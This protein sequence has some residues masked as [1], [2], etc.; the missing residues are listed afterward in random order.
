MQEMEPASPPRKF[1][2][3]NTRMQT[4]SAPAGTAATEAAAVA[5]AV[6][7]HDASQEE[8]A[9]ANKV[10]DGSTTSN[11]PPQPLPASHFGVGG[12]PPAGT[13]CSSSSSNQVP[14]TSCIA[15]VTTVPSSVPA[16]NN[17]ATEP[18]TTPPLLLGRVRSEPPPPPPSTPST[19]SNGAPRSLAHGDCPIAPDAA[20]AAVTAADG[21][22]AAAAAPPFPSPPSLS[23]SPADNVESPP[24]SAPWLVERALSIKAAIEEAV[25]SGGGGGSAASGGGGEAGGGGVL[26]PAAQEANARGIEQ[27]AGGRGGSAEVFPHGVISKVCARWQVEDGYEL[28]QQVFREVATTVVSGTTDG[29]ESM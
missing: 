2:S 18:A 7:D 1:I 8:T 20:A 14:S 29:M 25:N 16:T 10:R 4:E 13:I 23:L 27:G 9:P 17:Q 21:G 22:A 28:A 15:P 11:G 24:P 3:G 26:L 6:H 19:S 12:P 5:V